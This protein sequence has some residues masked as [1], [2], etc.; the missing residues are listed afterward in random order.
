MQFPIVT[1][2]K[3]WRWSALGAWL[4][5]AL[6][7]AG[8][9]Q[10]A[11]LGGDVLPYG[12]QLSDP[13]P[14]L[15]PAGRWLVDSVGRVVLL[16]G[17][18]EVEKSPPFYPA[19]IGADDADFLARRGL[20]V[21]RLGVV[22]EALMPEP[23]QIDGDYIEHLA[24]IVREL[25]ARHIFVVLDFHQDG[26]GPAVHGNGM[27]AWATLTDGLP[28]P[29]Q[30][31]PIY[32]ITNHALQRAFDNFWADRTAP[33]GIGLQEHYA[34]AARA[35]A[36]R[37]RGEPYVLGFEAMNEPWPGTD[38]LACITDCRDHENQLL[39]PFYE[40][41]A[42]AVH[43]A[44]DDALILVE[45]F[46]L[47]NFGH[48][49]SWLPAIGAP[50]NVFAFHAYALTSRDNLAAMDHAIA[51]AERTSSALLAT[52]WG[53]TYDPAVV[54]TTSAQ[55]DD[56]LVPWIFWH[57]SGQMLLDKALPPTPDNLRTD[58]VAAVTR[59][60]PLT[61]NGTPLALAFDPSTRELTYEFATE[62]TD[63]GQ[64]RPSLPS[65]IVVPR[66]VY[67]DGY[68]VDVQGAV[69]TS[70]P[71]AERLEIRN[72]PK[73]TMVSVQVTPAPAP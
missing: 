6:L 42:E 61:T 7:V 45:P 5:A 3:H 20:Y 25:G 55:F 70:R 73:A 46:V 62:R 56:R 34:A 30:P 51:A 9:A 38:W 21:L 14:P 68:R 72:L 53:A 58:V 36:E 15:R 24:G 19:G 60:Y 69:V 63:G 17:V 26:Y 1:R 59:P 2:S 66:A 28:N 64:A 27:P 33:D 32:Y 41:F 37:L 39:V 35:L 18:N 29:V 23:G 12:R 48:A 44:D 31:F 8:E 65:G 13:V 47:F 10:A 67:P 50:S 49:D 43:A 54:E 22:F 40:R 52:E 16:H 71:G 4:I 11:P 57:Y